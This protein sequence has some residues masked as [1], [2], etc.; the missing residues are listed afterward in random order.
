MATLKDA[1]LNR[2]LLQ[3]LYDVYDDVLSKRPSTHSTVNLKITNVGQFRSY[4][5]RMIKALR[6]DLAKIQGEYAK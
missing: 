4:S 2:A 5:V 6:E 3:Q 1:E